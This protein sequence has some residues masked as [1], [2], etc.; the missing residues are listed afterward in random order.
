MNPHSLTMIVSTFARADHWAPSSLQLLCS[1]A[2]RTIDAFSAHHAATMLAALGQLRWDHP[3]ACVALADRLS[4]LTEPLSI[5]LVAVALRA[6]SRLPSSSSDKCVS[7]LL[8]ALDRSMLSEAPS[9][10]KA[11]AAELALLSNALLHLR[12]LP[13]Q[14]L[15][16]LV[17]Q[18]LQLHHTP[19][20]TS[21]RRALA[22]LSIASRTWQSAF[23]S[24]D[25]PSTAP[26]ELPSQGLL[27][28]ATFPPPH[29]MSFRKLDLQES[30]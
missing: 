30:A 23:A 4:R 18:Q 15:Y 1:H 8:S 12:L 14:P 3:Q 17:Q 20:T 26:S 16:S 21:E 22:K 13:S 5:P 10:P 7:A 24:S 19:H 27:P 2:V 6:A 25:Q 11:S 29:E 9:P 28:T